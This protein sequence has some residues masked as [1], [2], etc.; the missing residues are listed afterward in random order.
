[1]NT[2]RGFH[3]ILVVGSLFFF[4]ASKA[5]QE[6]HSQQTAKDPSAKTPIGV[7]DSSAREAAS[8]IPAKLL[9]Y[10]QRIVKK[11]DRNGSGT[12][13][14]SEWGA[15]SGDA[16]KVDRNRNGAITVEELADYLA[17]YSRLHPLQDKETA[18]QHLPQPPAMIFQPASPSGGSR[19]KATASDGP[20]AADQKTPEEKPGKERARALRKYHVADSALPAG[21]PDWFLDG[22]SDG[23]GQLTLAEFASDGSS[24]QRRLFA[25]RDQNGDGVI[26]PDEILHLVKK[27]P[28][29]EK[30]STEATTQPEKKSP[31]PS[32]RR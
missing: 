8:A 4:G 21:L 29:K 22:D 9:R 20:P 5:Q 15:I 27:S 28:E 12:L 30:S 31:A 16:L 26:T 6:N 13:E 11:Y 18:W 7:W 23:D 19:E 3:W 2:N 14:A 1:M 25:Q 17:N 10:A 32:D 24:A